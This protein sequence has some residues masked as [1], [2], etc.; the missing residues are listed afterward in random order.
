VTAATSR[1]G[2]RP[3]RGPEGHPMEPGPET[4]AVPE[5]ACSTG[6]DEEGGLEG[7][8]GVVLVPEDASAGR[9][10]HGPVLA[11]QGLEGD[12]GHLAVRRDDPA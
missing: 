10:D 9:Q 7:V 11:D 2:S 8:L 5:G 12:G 6:Q 3:L 4:I 1:L